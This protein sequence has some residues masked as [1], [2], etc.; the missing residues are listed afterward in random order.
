MDA[1]STIL[2]EVRRIRNDFDLF[3]IV[4]HSY[5]H[6]ARELP[7][8]RTIITCHDL[9][10]FRCLTT[11]EAEPRNFP[12]KAMTR[13]ILARPPICCAR[14]LRHRSHS[15]RHSLHRLLPPER[16][17]VVHNGVSPDLSPNEDPA[18]DAE[19]SHLLNR[20]GEKQLELLHVGST[21]PA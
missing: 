7:P 18:A 4:D 17:T 3:H 9:D 1:S 5:A 15:S 14:N 21:I 6:L 20:N 11:P 16:L 2:R 8:S 19:L 13:R 12:F 10:A